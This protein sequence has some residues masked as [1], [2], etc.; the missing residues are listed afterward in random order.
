MKTVLFEEDLSNPIPYELEFLPG[1]FINIYDN[2]P[3]MYYSTVQN[4]ITAEHEFII[5]VKHSSQSS[6]INLG[7]MIAEGSETLSL[8]GSIQLVKGVDYEETT[9]P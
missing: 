3:S 7:F 8:D 6:T 2:G 4:N 9:P 5:Q 1:N